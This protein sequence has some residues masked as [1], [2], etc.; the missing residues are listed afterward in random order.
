MLRRDVSRSYQEVMK[1]VC[2]MRL[3][4][5]GLIHLLVLAIIVTQEVHVNNCSHVITADRCSYRQI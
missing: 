4:P 3:D 5:A 2:E 1:L